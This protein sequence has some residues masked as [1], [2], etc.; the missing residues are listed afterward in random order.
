MKYRFL[1]LSSLCVL[2]I[3]VQADSVFGEARDVESFEIMCKS[4]RYNI[5]THFKLL[6]GIYSFFTVTGDSTEKV[7]LSLTPNRVALADKKSEYS[8]ERTVE[9]S[10]I[11]I[12][13]RKGA[14][15]FD[16][17]LGEADFM[18]ITISTDNDPVG[19]RWSRIN[20]KSIEALFDSEGHL[21]SI[22]ESD[23]QKERCK[24]V[25]IN[26]E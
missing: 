11:I 23:S 16:T 4:E 21:R 6:N 18:T 3:C 14:E 8:T 2:S 15:F 10:E 13:I 12:S 24:L 25:D 26:F 20:I 5:T 19:N 17:T 9:W 22:Y 1:I 7:L